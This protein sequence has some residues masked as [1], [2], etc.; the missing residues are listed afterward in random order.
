VDGYILSLQRIPRGRHAGAGV[1]GLGPPVLLQHGVL[2][3][4]TCARSVGHGAKHTF[5]HF[6][7]SLRTLRSVPSSMPVEAVGVLARRNIHD[8]CRH[9]V[10][11]LSVAQDIY[12]KENRVFH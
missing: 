6:V 12:S 5:M 11:A 4:R 2:V 7:A 10:F 9:R 8:R 1:A 3:V